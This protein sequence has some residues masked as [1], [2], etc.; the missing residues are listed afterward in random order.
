[1]KAFKLFGRK[2]EKKGYPTPPSIICEKPL[3]S[4]PTSIEKDSLK[5]RKVREALK[6]FKDIYCKRYCQFKEDKLTGKSKTN[7]LQEVAISMR[8]NH[9]WVNTIKRI[10]HVDGIEV[11]DKFQY[12]AELCVIGLHNQFSSGIDYMGKDM[13]SLATSIVVTSRYSN[14]MKSNGCLVY[15]GQGGNPKV[16]SNVSPHDQKLEAG[17]LALKNSMEARSPV[18]VILKVCRKSES[19]GMDTWSNPEYSFIYDGLYLVNQMTQERGEYG[20]LVFKF[21]LNKMPDQPTHVAP[22]NV[23]M[24]G[25]FASSRRKSKG[26]VAQKHIVRVND[27]SNGKEKFPIRVVTPI[28]HGQMPASFEYMVNLV[29]GDRL[30]QPIL[31][32]CDCRESC[33][34]CKK[35]SC[36]VKNG[37][38]MPYNCNKRLAYPN[39]SSL[40]YECGPSCK[41]SSSCINRVS[42]CGIQVQLE[43]FKTE[44]KGWGVR[45]RSF[46][47]RGCFVC[48]FIGEVYHIHNRKA[49]S[50]P[51]ADDDFIL[52]IGVGKGFI[53]ATNRG[54]IARF[55]NHSCTP[56]LCFKDVIYDSNNKSIPHKMLFAV[57]D[58][59]SGRE[60]TY[61]YNSCKGKIIKVRNND[62]YC[63]SRECNGQIYF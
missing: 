6:T 20:K 13:N 42:Q 22:E 63:G 12:R 61:N 39:K 21:T 31:F 34:D 37:G 2:H 11:G 18:R 10:G 52:S 4:F 59:P 44:Y 62:C 3:N 35:C 32:G 1:M 5:H 36:I 17:N 24:D 58:I 53:D 33:I 38:T 54:N 60:L 48:E 29:Y 16:G 15:E 50:R 30:N 49:R 26:S 27:V 23:V 57:K 46:I 51:V 45:T 55:I 25:Q 8:M 14:V 56:N 47:R 40:I 41:C 9:Q 43:I 7:T 19:D 28:D